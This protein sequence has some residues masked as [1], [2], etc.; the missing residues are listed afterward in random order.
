MKFA[1][2]GIPFFIAA[3]ILTLVVYWF[4]RHW[5]TGLPV[6]ILFFMFFFFRDPD[7]VTPSQADAIIAPADGK[8]I[9][10]KQTFEKDY[11]K[12]EVLQFSIFMSPLN[13]HVNRAPFDG[14]VVSVKHTSGSFHKAYLDEASSNNENI[15][16]VMAT[17]M[18]DI[19]VRQVAGSVARRAVCR[20]NPGDVLKKGQ[21]F[22]IIKFSSRVDLYLPPEAQ[23]T[24][25][26]GD[27]L[28]AG[29]TVIGRYNA[30]P[31]TTK[32]NQGQPSDQTPGQ[33][34]QQT[35]S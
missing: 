17:P 20:V 7:R 9:V 24:A 27:K 2:E 21:R 18:G 30:A 15:A 6:M 28:K 12:R 26:V 31:N 22:G 3:L 10:I 16:M 13:V 25:Q 14:T 1:P 11:L 19:L 5:V 34:P 29:E 35:P 33:T 23:I 8:V 4:T 32:D